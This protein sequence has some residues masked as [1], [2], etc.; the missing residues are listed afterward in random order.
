MHEAPSKQWSNLTSYYLIFTEFH[1][2]YR[3]L[4]ELLQYRAASHPPED[5]WSV[6][7]SG[8]H[9]P[10]INSLSHLSNQDSKDQ[11]LGCCDIVVVFTSSYHWHLSILWSMSFLSWVTSIHF[12]HQPFWPKLWRK[13]GLAEKGSWPMAIEQRKVWTGACQ[14][15][16]STVRCGYS[17]SHAWIFPVLISASPGISLKGRKGVG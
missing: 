8:R 17:C 10:A 11:I 16:A 3:I 7:G 9:P 14:F 15:L 2:K 12:L 1:L 5:F 13:E 4:W 6:W